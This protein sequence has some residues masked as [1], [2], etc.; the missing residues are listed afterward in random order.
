M[1]EIAA[2]A[3]GQ[4]LDPVGD[5][6]AFQ[7]GVKRGF[8]DQGDLGIG[9]AGANGAEQGQRH[10]DIAEPVGQT[11][12]D[13]GAAGQGDQSAGGQIF[14]DLEVVEEMT[15]DPPAA[16]DR[17]VDAMPVAFRVD[18]AARL[19]DTSGGA[20]VVRA[21]RAA[22]DD[23]PP[24]VAAWPEPFDEG[25]GLT[26]TD[27]TLAAALPIGGPDEMLLVAR[28]GGPEFLGSELARISHLTAL[29]RSIR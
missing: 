23:I 8:C 18:W 1:R 9:A 26:L 20:A 3:R 25:V 24:L 11:D 12:P 14:L 28:R 10:H 2:V 4:G 16:L 5:P 6:P 22:P 27:E 21:T 13:A 19:K 15:S 29:A 7:Q 17:L